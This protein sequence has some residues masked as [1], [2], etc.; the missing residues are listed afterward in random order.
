MACGRRAAG[1][2]QRY[3]FTG[4]AGNSVAVTVGVDE[5]SSETDDCIEFANFWTIDNELAFDYP[6]TISGIFSHF[7]VTSLHVPPKFY[8]EKFD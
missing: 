8:P 4:G 3:T 2:T 1:D 7:P 6:L 5:G